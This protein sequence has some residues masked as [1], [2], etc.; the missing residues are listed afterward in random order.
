VLAFI[1]V[2]LGG[3]AREA[4]A[5]I[6]GFDLGTS[7]SSVAVVINGSSQAIVNAD[8]KVTMPSVISLAIDGAVVV[9]DKAVDE[10]RLSPQCTIFD[11]KRFIGKR[12]PP[13]PLPT[14]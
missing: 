9:G 2:F 13:S 8:G 1:S 6:V 7:T 12:Y 4:P 10:G 11:A 14:P 5:A 3:F